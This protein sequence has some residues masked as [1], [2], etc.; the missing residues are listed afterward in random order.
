VPDPAAG[1][2][3]DYSG[4]FPNFATDPRTSEA[5]D[6]YGAGPSSDDRC[7]LTT[8]IR[9]SSHDPPLGYCSSAVGPQPVLNRGAGQE[10]LPRRHRGVGEP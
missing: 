3:D 6:R 2:L 4:S 9:S 7:P 8:A 1:V 10:P 5:F